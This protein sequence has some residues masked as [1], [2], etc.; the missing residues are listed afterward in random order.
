MMMSTIM[1]T[2]MQPGLTGL[3]MHRHLAITT[4]I[5]TMLTAIHLTGMATGALALMV[6]ADSAT[7]HTA[8]GALVWVMVLAA[9]ALV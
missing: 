6:M 2:V 1:T 7:G 9:G 5:I 3:T 4:I 8:T